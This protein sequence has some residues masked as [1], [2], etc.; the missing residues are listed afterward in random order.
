MPPSQP[1]FARLV[2]TE[3]DLPP[4][5]VVSIMELLDA[6]CTVPFIA[7]Y[8]KDA[9][10]GA[11]DLTIQLVMERLEFH[12]DFHQRRQTILA[13][14]ESQGKLSEE[15]RRQIDGA[16]TK[17]EL[18]DL[19]LPY[20]PK[21]R[22][23][24]T[25]ARE[26]GLEPL[27]ERMWARRERSGSIIDIARDFVDAD[28]EVPTMDDALRGARDIVAERIVETP[29]WRAV[30]R[31]LT[32][33]EGVVRCKAARG[34]KDVASKFSDYYDHQERV[35]QIATHRVLAILRGEKEGFL[36]F[37]VG[38]EPERAHRRL[39]DQVMGSGRSI[40]D[41]QLREATTDGYDRL[42]SSQIETEIRAELKIRADREAI[43]VFASNLE[44]LLMLP[45]F[46][47]R[48][49]LAVDPGFRT[50]CKVVVLSATGQL[51][52]H[53]VV[54][55]TEPR[56]DLSGTER[57]L[58]AWF[59]KYT[60]LAAVVVGNGTGGRETFAWLR[61]YLKDR[62]H[63]AI[64]IMVNE[65]G[66]SIYSA[67][68]IAREELPDHDVTVRGAVSIGRRVQDPLAEL[69]KIDPKSIGV[70]QYQHD[71]D[72]K[73]LRQRLDEVV[74]RC[75][76]RV[77]VDV[78]T[79]SPSILN[80][81]SGL[82]PKLAQAMT[83][84]RDTHGAF[85]SRVQLKKVPGLGEKTFVQAAGFLRVK[86]ANPLDDSA[87]HPERYALVKSMAKDL[88][89][90]IRELIGDRQTVATIDRAR[91][92][93]DS[94]GEY[95]LSDILA[96]LEKP[97]RDPRDSFEAVEYRDD[98]NEMKDLREG[99]ILP[100]VVTNVTSFGAF[101]DVGVHQDGL[102]HVSQ[103][104]N[105]YVQEPA[106]ELSVGQ[107]VRVKVMSVDLDRGRIGLSIKEAG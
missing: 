74:G 39:T 106:D 52:D 89:R 8:R 44:D 101:V 99:M 51:L 10:G 17:T 85:A 53:G 37:R 45:P 49:L 79:A 96:E 72:Q 21:R 5:V 71:V 1:D 36:S 25:I 65:S 102:V 67:S 73:R 62:G 18:E 58:D 29:E 55:P 66:A 84:Y 87:V 50:G 16:T 97:G 93:D 94:V 64:P 75:V 41:E 40:W 57:A 86:G 27:A 83:L 46:G 28:K 30:I 68:Q 80:Y 88:G 54:Y 2:A 91:Y 7:R 26:R 104:A 95:T 38:A 43:D 56:R 92:L 69:V 31:D 12:R 63:G 98:V 70:G 78:N 42:L 19:Y 15:L 103:I 34:K 47:S 100:G 13:G 77:G 81:V 14:I 35:S 61:G 82:G 23:R 9:T 59:R 11:E 24:A 107:P 60:D 76:N 33:K 105:R 32:W 4:K 3:A 20:R 90:D 48:P 6:G 22:T